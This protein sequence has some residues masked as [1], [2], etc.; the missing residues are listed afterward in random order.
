MALAGVELG[1]S[2]PVALQDI[3]VAHRAFRSLKAATSEATISSYKR[4]ID[5]WGYFC[6]R[7]GL[8]TLPVDPENVITWLQE[9][10]ESGYKHS[11]LKMYLNGVAQLDRFSRMT[12]SDPHPVGVNRHHLVQ[13]WFAAYRKLHLTPQNQAP[14]CTPQ[15]WR[16]IFLQMYAPSSRGENFTQARALRRSRDRALLLLG[17]YVAARR[18]E[19]ARFRVGEIAITPKGAEVFL[20]HQ[21]NKQAG[22]TVRVRRQAEKMLCPVS[23]LE[24]WLE[25]LEQEGHADSL[26][27][28]FMGIGHDGKLSHVGLTDRM[29]CKVVSSRA[30]G[31]GIALSAHS[32]RALFAVFAED[33]GHPP[34]LVMQHGRWRSVSSY[35]RYARRGRDWKHNATR[36]LAR[37][38]MVIDNEGD[39]E[40]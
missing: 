25:V 16:S 27:P 2:V 13:K 5:R 32:L 28:L 20:R 40:Q 38:S 29:V 9:M 35:E 26:A 23:A 18:A 15:E 14:I 31:A 6:S 17:L 3:D 30:R 39:D 19:L 8:P 4:G 1:L 12:P 21:K 11:S 24:H 22:Q 33:A 37:L 7:H 34:G 10:H 36:G